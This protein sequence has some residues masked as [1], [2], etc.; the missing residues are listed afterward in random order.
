M[1]AAGATGPSVADRGL[2]AVF[3]VNLIQ[4]VNILR[5][6]AVMAHRDFGWRVRL[7]VAGKFAGR[8]I[9]GVWQAE[10]AQLAA[11]TGA[12]IRVFEN[13]FEALAALT[14][15]GMVFAASESNLH[16]HAVPHDVMRIAPPS[17]L[18]VTLQHG[19]ECVGFRHSAAHTLAH[20]ADASFAADIVC[21]W[22][23]RQHLSANTPSQRAK[24]IVTGPSA[25]LQQHR[26]PFDRA[27]DAPG[28]VCE[29]LHSVRMNA[30]GDLKAEF[31]DVFAAFC[32]G[33]EG[34]G[35]GSRVCLRPH[36]G[37]QYTVRNNVPLPANATLENAPIYRVDLRRFAYGISAPSSVLLDMVLA[38]IPTAVWRDG[39]GR[40]DIDNY[41]DLPGISTVDDWI[42]F[43]RQ[44]YVEPE[45]FAAGRRAF[46]DR[47]GLLTDPADVYARY[48]ALFEYACRNA[49][50]LAAAVR[51]GGLRFH[52][53]EPN[54]A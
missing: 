44:A 15:H 53:A 43:A 50:A 11:A 38:G 31:V 17:Y 19:F 7:L 48:A 12:R 13:E 24:V 3:I 54:A 42:A 2:E 30:M 9:S 20:G 1:I 22:F 34:G 28:L 46:L 5:P 41:A 18:C 4:D 16:G 49:A 36:P 29:N 37:G 47:F 6:L 33:I 51:T 14:G 27:P 45:S 25:V 39:K 21:A 10:L 40:M 23:E 32:T 26:D 8:D 35:T 52:L